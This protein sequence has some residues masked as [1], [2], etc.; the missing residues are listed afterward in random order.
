MNEGLKR[1]NW[2][3]YEHAH[4]WVLYIRPF[5]LSSL[6]LQCLAMFPCNKADF[7]G[8]RLIINLNQ[9]KYC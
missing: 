7:N 8:Q 2:F 1:N 3:D 9:N 4:F 5:L 6:F